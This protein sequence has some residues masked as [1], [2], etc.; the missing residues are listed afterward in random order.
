MP[1][2]TR[3]ETHYGGIN[4]EKELVKLLNS[5]LDVNINSYFTQGTNNIPIWKHLGGTTQKADCEV[6]IGNQCFDISI[7]NHEN[8]G[9]FDWINTSK[10]EEFNEELG[11]SVKKSIDNFKKDNYGNE[12]TKR[13]RDDLANIFNSEFDHITSDQIKILLNTLYIK[14]PKY[15]L[16]NHCSAKSLIMYPKE[17]NFPEFVEYSDWEYFL[18]TSRAKTS[19]MIFRR[20][21]GVE[22]NTNLR[23]R[24]V[25]NNG[26]GALIGKSE[27]NKNSI[28]C[29][30]IQQDKVETLISK[31]VNTITDKYSTILNNE[32]INIESVK[33]PGL[34]LLADVCSQMVPLT[35]Q[36]L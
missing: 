1:Y 12:I 32:T 29:L 27:K 22:V 8:T 33:T 6:N 25:L 20:K 14:Y 28:S 15:V 5:K 4:N 3:G 17:N 19:R 16:I 24:M 13:M 23:L 9:T 35:E 18:K 36:S 7:K 2:K 10:L 30:K 31:L 26:L 21:D 11:K 34:D